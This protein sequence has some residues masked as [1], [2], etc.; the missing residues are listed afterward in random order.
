MTID[1]VK[2]SVEDLKRCV[3]HNISDEEVW[4][5]MED[6]I[7]RKVLQAIA[8]RQISPEETAEMLA[9]EAVKTLDLQFGRFYS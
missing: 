5:Q 8:Y 3:Q 4:H 1:E 2:Q 6:S 7:H 9:T